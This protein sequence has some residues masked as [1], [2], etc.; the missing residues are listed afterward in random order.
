MCIA[1]LGSTSSQSLQEKMGDAAEVQSLSGQLHIWLEV[2]RGPTL[3]ILGV[4]L[5]APQPSRQ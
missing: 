3:L 1:F 5:G 2:P 4:V